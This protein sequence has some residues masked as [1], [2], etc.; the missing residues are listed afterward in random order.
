MSVVE[1]I[2]E[3]ADVRKVL[4][5]LGAEHLSRSGEIRCCCPIHR[6]DNA[7][8]FVINESTGMWFCHTGCL[9]GGDLF[10][11]VMQSEEVTFKQ[12]VRWIAELHNMEVDW[13]KEVVEENLF[14]NE[15]RKFIDMMRKRHKQHELPAFKV[16]NMKFAKVKDYRGYSAETLDF[17][18]IRYCTEGEL[19]DRIVMAL[20][21]VDK[22]LVGITGRATKAEQVEKFMHRPRNLHT[23]YFLTG[24]GR[25]LKFVQEAN[26]TV[27]I[28]EGL[29]DSAKW[30]DCGHKNVCCPIGIFFT[31]EHIRQLYKAGV[32][33][34]EFAFDNDKAGRNGT[35]KAIEK[36]KGKFELYCL[37]YPEGKDADDC[38]QEELEKVAKNRLNIY[39]WY[40]QFGEDVEK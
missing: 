6:G 19:K 36:A 37:V 20:E 25:N 15:A 18:K 27:K 26:N 11:L 35:R 21:D 30:W 12:A 16:Q 34:L 31:E 24:L 28:V 2:R 10:D 3:Q 32:T 17:W 40:E 29:F 33:T 9:D 39:E 1:R 14:R 7:T 5:A 23:G 13:T 38:T 4:K 22:R 8:A